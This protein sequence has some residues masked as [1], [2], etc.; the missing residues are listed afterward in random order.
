MYVVETKGLHLKDNEKTEYIRKVFDLCNKESKAMNWEKLGQA[1][2][3]KVLRFE[4]LS[5]E[6]WEG[7]LNEMLL[8]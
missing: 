1:I 7:K 8:K 5:E 4:V 2:E 6:E 3:R